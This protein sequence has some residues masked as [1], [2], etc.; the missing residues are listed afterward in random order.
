MPRNHRHIVLD[1]PTPPP[2]IG[3]GQPVLEPILI[4]TTPTPTLMDLQID[5]I[6]FKTL[7]KYATIEEALKNR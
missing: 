3:F 1:E 7:G 2:Y 5:H 6:S 4:T